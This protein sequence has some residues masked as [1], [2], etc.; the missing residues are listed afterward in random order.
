MRPRELLQNQ[1]Q[2]ASRNQGGSFFRDII[3]ELRRSTWPTREEA[4]RL[5]I[6]VIIVGSIMGAFLW[7]VDSIFGLL[8]R[9]LVLGG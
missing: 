7:L 1:R 9:V 4:T 2:D 8:I 6:M 3:G 5:T